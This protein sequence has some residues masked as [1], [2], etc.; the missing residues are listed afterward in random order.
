MELTTNLEYFRN[1]IADVIRIFFPMERFSEEQ[2]KT[3][4]Y[5]AKHRMTVENGKE[6]HTAEFYGS[7]GLLLGSGCFS[8]VVQDGTELEQKKRQKRG[9]IPVF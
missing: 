1:D 3:P 4:E 8:A 5:R 6:V 9:I 2:E 7:D